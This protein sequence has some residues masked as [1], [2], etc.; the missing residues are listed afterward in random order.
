MPLGQTTSC[1][2][3]RNGQLLRQETDDGVVIWERD[4]FGNEKKCSDSGADYTTV[5]DFAG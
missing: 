1:H 4:P 2:Y 5:R 3:D